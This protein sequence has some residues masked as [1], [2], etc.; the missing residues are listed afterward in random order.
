[1]PAEPLAS[2]PFQFPCQAS[3]AC[4]QRQPAVRHPRPGAS[5][6]CSIPVPEHPGPAGTARHMPEPFPWSQFSLKPQIIR[7]QPEDSGRGGLKAQIWELPESRVLTKSSG[8][9]PAPRKLQLPAGLGCRA[10]SGG[11]Q[12]ARSPPRAQPVAGHARY[13][14]K[15]QTFSLASP[16]GGCSCPAGR[17]AGGEL[18]PAAVPQRLHI[19]PP[20]GS[21][22]APLSTRS[23]QGDKIGAGGCGGRGPFYYYYS[24]IFWGLVVPAAR[25]K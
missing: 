8:L 3:C 23:F 1:M 20:A 2:P 17:G 4:L 19:D 9:S 24:N 7:P 11:P 15:A 25:R 5:R 16:R 12:A 10:G 18:G 6:C 22:A 14:G 21:L 13:K